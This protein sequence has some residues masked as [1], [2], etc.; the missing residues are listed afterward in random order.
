[1]ATNREVALEQAL[2][3]VIGAAKFDGLDEKGLVDRATALLLGG[4]ALRVV[5][6]PN[7]SDAIRE[8]SDAQAE[9]VARLQVKARPP[10]HLDQASARSCWPLR[11]V[12]LVL[13]RCKK[14][15][16][17]AVQAGAPVQKG[18]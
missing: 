11:T 3:A 17:Q 10:C 7:V 15:A 5:D 4:N 6:H 13:V 12:A 1:M 18:Q 8:I 14:L 16:R 2:V 9:A